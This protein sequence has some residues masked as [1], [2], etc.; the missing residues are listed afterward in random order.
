MAAGKKTGGREAGTPNKA[1]KNFREQINLFLCKN[2]NKVQRD[3]D[4]MDPKDRL[5]F[6]EKLLRY[7]T[8]ALTSAAATIDYEKLCDE[9]L[10]L[11][12][13]RIMRY[14]K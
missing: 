6:I 13:D 8:P 11:L 4:K 2:W 7:T 12:V 3:F 9:D 10:D 1:T 5:Q 14:Q